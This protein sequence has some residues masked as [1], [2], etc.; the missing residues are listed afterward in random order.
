MRMMK[1]VVPLIIGFTILSI[2]LGILGV[3]STEAAESEPVSNSGE[4]Y[5]GVFGATYYTHDGIDISPL[6][7]AVIHIEAKKSPTEVVSGTGFFFEQAG[8]LYL[9]T[10]RHMVIKE[11]DG[12]KPEGIQ[13]FM[14]TKARD[15]T[16]GTVYTVK[17]YDEKGKKVWLEHPVYKEYADVVAIRL[18]NEY[19][20]KEFVFRPFTQDNLPTKTDIFYV[21]E[22]VIV[23]GFPLNFYDDYNNLPVVR[24]GIVASFYLTGFRNNPYFL[25]D[26]RLHSGTSGSPVLGKPGKARS[27][28]AGGLD[29]NTIAKIYLLGIHSDVCLKSGKPGVDEPLGL[30]TAWYAEL[31]PEIINEHVKP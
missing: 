2:Y 6:A 26:A 9:I 23:I 21:G 24:S 14:H 3:T 29:A 5:A 25:I 13:F 10:N 11:A 27:T 16:K 22:D 30:N 8:A 15:L 17:L 4:A 7:V 31:I 1:W 12:Y 18:D 28:A 20:K 19:F